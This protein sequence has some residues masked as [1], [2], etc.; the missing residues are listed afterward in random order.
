MITR[1]SWFVYGTLLAIWI[2]L[3]GWQIAE[4]VRVRRSAQAALINRAKDISNTLGLLMRS[5]RFFGV[6]SKERLESALNELVSKGEL[7][8]VVLLNATNEIVASAG[9]PIELQSRGDLRGGEHWGEQTVTL[10][11]LVDLGTNV[12]QELERTNLTIIMPASELF[13]PF[14]TNR[15][16]PPRMDGDAPPPPDST[17]GPRRR[18]NWHR[19]GGTNDFNSFERP[20]WMKVEDYQSIIQKKGVHSFI[21]VMSAQSLRIL[22]NQDLWLRSIIGILA[23][24]SVVGSGLAWRN[25]AKTSEL[26]IRLV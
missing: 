5:Q 2:I 24:I 12:T 19:R 22:S 20:Y 6:I 26:Q 21:I 11:N 10:E 17:N 23:T 8:S 4:H 15:P 18:F 25:L 7:H 13:G 3:I 1:R 9:A 16:P 14:G